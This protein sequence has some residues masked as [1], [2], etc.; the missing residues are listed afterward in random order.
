MGDLI[1]PRERVQANFEA[2]LPHG[3]G[4][5]TFLPGFF[6]TSLSQIPKETRLSVLRLDGDMY[7]RCCPTRRIVACS[8]TYDGAIRVVIVHQLHGFFVQPL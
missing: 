5:V 8:L 4:P 6:N 1:V 3:H 2:F 7:E